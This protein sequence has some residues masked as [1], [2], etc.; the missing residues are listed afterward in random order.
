MAPSVEKWYVTD[1]IN[2]CG[3]FISSR[4][5]RMKLS[6]WPLANRAPISDSDADVKTFIRL[7]HSV[8]RDPFVGVG[9]GCTTGSCTHPSLLNAIPPV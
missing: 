6:C 7:V 9:Y 3:C 2:G 5:V 8:W 1:S 4:I